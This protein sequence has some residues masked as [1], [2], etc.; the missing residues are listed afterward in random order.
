M[1]RKAPHDGA[2]TELDMLSVFGIRHL[3]AGPQKTL[4]GPGAVSG[5]ATQK[6]RTATGRQQ[7]HYGRK[8]VDEAEIQTG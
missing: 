8:V 5:R 6:V 7:V 2:Y 4:A 1:V 3:A